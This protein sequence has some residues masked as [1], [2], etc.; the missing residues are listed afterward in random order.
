MTR[1]PNATEKKETSAV[2]VDDADA[3]HGDERRQKSTLA[4]R[5]E[6]KRKKKLL[7]T[8]TNV[9]GRKKR[10]RNLPVPSSRKKKGGEKKHHQQMGSTFLP[11]TH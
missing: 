11:I 9:K 1:K 2:D 5:L 4:C 10:N 7:G 8:T 6:N 3:D